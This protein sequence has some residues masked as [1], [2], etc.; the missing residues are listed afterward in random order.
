M[1]EARESPKETAEALFILHEVT[2]DPIYRDWSFEIFEAIERHCRT[3]IAYGAHPDVTSA[4]RTPDDRME[5]FALAETFKYLY[6][7]Q[8][9]DRGGIDLDHYVFNTE[10][11]PM[12]IWSAVDAAYAPRAL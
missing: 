7:I 1:R 6:L 8:A 3:H 10:A 9:E 2:G 4:S 11:H 12:R 5:S